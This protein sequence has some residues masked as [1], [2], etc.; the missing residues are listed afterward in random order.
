MSLLV[1]GHLSVSVVKGLWGGRGV[2]RLSKKVEW[3]G[4]CFIHQL[5]N[6]DF[7]H[8]LPFP[9]LGFFN[10]FKYFNFFFFFLDKRCGSCH[11]N[12]LR[13]IGR[14]PKTSTLATCPFSAPFLLS[15]CSWPPHSSAHSLT[16]S[17]THSLTHPLTHSLTRLVTHFPQQ[18]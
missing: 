16:H 15:L 1:R 4:D 18:G 13:S 7:C 5:S 9:I 8:L 12:S 11:N 2:E 6:S 14:G 17:P 3:L 10:F